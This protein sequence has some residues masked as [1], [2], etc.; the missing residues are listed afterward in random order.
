MFKCGRRQIQGFCSKENLQVGWN[1]LVLS[2]TF[3]LQNHFTIFNLCIELTTHVSLGL[4]CTHVETAVCAKLSTSYFLAYQLLA[5]DSLNIPGITF[6]SNLHYTQPV[7]L[8][9][10]FIKEMF[11]LSF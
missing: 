8:K 2:K 6:F 10:N 4:V 5:K 9:N 7:C 3:L 1:H 11:L